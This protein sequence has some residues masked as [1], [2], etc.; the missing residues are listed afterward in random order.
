MF[1]GSAL[2]MFAIVCQVLPS[3]SFVVSP[4]P[5]AQPLIRPRMRLRMSAPPALDAQ[6]GAQIFNAHCAACHA[7]EQIV[8]QAGR[9][10][11]DR[12]L[13]KTAIEKYMTGGFEE[14]TVATQIK[15]GKNAMPVFA[16]RLSEAEV[17][18]VA[19]YVIKSASE[20][21]D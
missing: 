2:V 11:T 14:K 1:S 5:L 18:L 13:G 10:L 20:G 17:G 21:W 6:T 4:M 3:A 8:M 19:A 9:M 15:N 12:T 16:E 7:G